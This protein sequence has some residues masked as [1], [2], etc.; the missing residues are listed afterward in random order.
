WKETRGIGIPRPFAR[1]TYEHSMREYGNDKPDLRFD[2]K[3]VD[4][5]DIVAGHRGAGISMC[6]SCAER[7]PGQIVKA[8]LV[9]ASAGLSRTETDK[10]EEIAKGMGAKGLA[11]AKVDDQGNWAKGRPGRGTL[12]RARAAATAAWRAKRADVCVS[13]FARGAAR[14]AV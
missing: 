13:R 3:H 2:M 7:R 5:T 1:M 11:R 8:M 12:P 9:P 6:S 14:H 4:L 10:L